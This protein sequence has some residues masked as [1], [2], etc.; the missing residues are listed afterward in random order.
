MGGHNH[1]KED[2]RLTNDRL[3]FTLT[4]TNISLSLLQYPKL[5]SPPDK[6]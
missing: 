4:N 2:V 3:F 5:L 6:N 1:S